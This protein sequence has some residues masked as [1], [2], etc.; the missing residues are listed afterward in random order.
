MWVLLSTAF[1]I[2]VVHNS[3]AEQLFQILQAVEVFEHGKRNLDG[4]APA[5]VSIA[6]ITHHRFW[7]GDCAEGIGAFVL[8]YRV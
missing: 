3:L 1:A 2:L 6:L 7:N 4:G 8:E 5:S